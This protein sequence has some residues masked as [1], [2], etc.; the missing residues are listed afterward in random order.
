MLVWQKKSV[1]P[2]RSGK[3]WWCAC[4]GFWTPIWQHARHRHTS[5]H[6]HKRKRR[7]RQLQQ[8]QQQQ[9]QHAI[10]LPTKSRK[11]NNTT[12]NAH[13]HHFVQE[14]VIR[15]SSFLL[16][17]S[18]GFWSSRE[19]FVVVTRTDVIQFFQKREAC[20]KIWGGGEGFERILHWTLV[21][22]FFFF[23]SFSRAKKNAI[24][25]SSHTKS[26]RLSRARKEGLLRSTKKAR[27]TRRRET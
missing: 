19:S 17:T 23:S 11:V 22:K 25:S 21:R 8:Q 13:H 9:Q 10:I 3:K 24:A 20:R 4:A 15:E 2:R 27:R 5:T 6:R 1:P 18:C 26:R 14:R 7:S 12:I 16:Y